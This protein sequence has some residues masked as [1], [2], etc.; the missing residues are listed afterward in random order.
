ME[1]CVCDGS[2]HLFVAAGAVPLTEKIRTA[3]LV[4]S[5]LDVLDAAEMV[6]VLSDKDLYTFTDGHPPSRDELEELYG[7]QVG[8]SSKDSET[9]HNW[10]LR[11]EGVC[12]GYVQATVMLQDSD[13]AW[14]VGVPWQGQGYATEAS[15]AVRDWLAVQGVNRF[16]AHIHPDHSAS[17]AVARN[18]GMVPTGDIDEEGEMIW[19]GEANPS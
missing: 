19:L 16:F 13:L 15:I 9:W 3:R 6:G 17:K 18:L 8:G 5:P 14:V 4:L 1:L 11:L 2:T 10:I 7:L 12:I